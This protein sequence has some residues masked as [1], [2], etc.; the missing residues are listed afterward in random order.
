MSN[1]ISSGRT[2]WLRASVF[3]A[4]LISAA[5]V[6]AQD[7]VMLRLDVE[8][9]Q[10]WKFDR[11][12]DEALNS[13]KSAGGQSYAMANKNHA[14]RVGQIEILAAKEGRPTSLRVTYGPD[15]ETTAEANG[16]PQKIPFPFAGQTI[17]VTREANGA[18][19]RSFRG[20]AEANA[21]AELDQMLDP[22]VTLYPNKQVAVGEEWAAAADVVNRQFGVTGPSD[23]AGMTLK[24]LAVKTVAGRPAAEIALATHATKDMGGVIRKTEA[25]GT[26]LIE[27]RSG[28]VL[29]FNL[30]G[31]STIAGTATGPGPNG[32]AVP[33]RWEG[34]G[35]MTQS[36][37]SEPVGG[38]IAV[39]PA[40]NGGAAV[41]AAAAPHG[42]NPLDSPPAAASH[43]ANPFDG[44]PAAPSAAAAPHGVNPLDSTPAPAASAVARVPEPARPPAPGPRRPRR[45]SGSRW[46]A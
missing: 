46:R 2:T 15:C 22:D 21:L 14:R 6:Y 28:H 27:V 39:A 38:E 23:S 26:A 25:K 36:L 43:G 12:Y 8:P 44:V 34:S 9:G 16:R 40:G 24:L 1:F 37:V 29:R 35:T 7:K 42:V 19:T 30:T 3:A 17:T 11:S 13:R 4:I 18:I 45:R 10:A 20:Q 33:I 5:S 32:R 41:P 31:T